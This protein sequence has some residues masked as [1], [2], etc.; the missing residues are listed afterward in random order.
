MRNF[1]SLPSVGEPYDGASVGYSE[2]VEYE[3]DETNNTGRT[4]NEYSFVQDGFT[5]LYQ[6]NKPNVVSYHYKRGLLQ[7]QT[8]QRKNPDFN[9]YKTIKHV[10]NQYGAFPDNSVGAV[11]LVVFEKIIYD[12]QTYC[13]TY[14]PGVILSPGYTWNSYS[15]STGDNKLIRSTTTSFNVYNDEGLVE[16]VDYIYGNQTHQQITQIKKFTS[17]GEELINENKY[18]AD[19]ISDPE[20]GIISQAMISANMISNPIEQSSFINKNNNNI[21]LKASKTKYKNWGSNIIAPETIYTKSL[22]SSYEPRLQYHAYDEKGNIK[23]VSKEGDINLSYLWNY[24][25][26]YPVAEITN[27]SPDR[28][29]YTSFETSDHGGWTI[30]SGSSIISL[31]GNITGRKSLSGSMSISVPQGNY[32]LSLWGST[33]PIVNGQAVSSNPLRTLSPVKKYFEIKLMNISSLT[34]GG[35]N[36]DEVRLYPIGAQMTTYTFDPLIGMTSQ[37]DINNRITYYEYDSYN[38]LSLIR[39][40][41]KN[42]VKMFCYNYQGQ[43]ESCTLFGNAPLTGNYYSQN[44]ASGYSAQV[45]PVTVPAGMFI[46]TSLLDANLQAAAYAQLQANQYG[47]CV[48]TTYLSMG[49]NNSTNADDYTVNFYNVATG[50][51]YNFFVG[52]NGI[53]PLGQIPA[54]TYNIFIASNTDYNTNER[55]YNVGC[56]YYSSGYGSASF[57]NIPLNASCTRIEIN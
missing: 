3:G 17:K 29:A 23:S 22:N 4:I 45:Y 41:N 30:N 46:S 48:I 24:N 43:P 6:Y 10:Y 55:I 16:T 42:I 26:T 1:V 15:V 2:V 7:Y 28:I 56:I 11:N 38:R 27:A 18:P 47:S 21:F 53:G 40:E 35:G 52:A 33:T 50:Q 34:I 5:S 54:G 9:S 49:Y 36:I 20:L 57:Y 37:C 44:C 31:D 39:D 8:T 25:K 12:D 19:F 13:I 51:S 14:D 32:L